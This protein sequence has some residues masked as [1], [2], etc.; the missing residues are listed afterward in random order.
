MAACACAWPWIIP[1]LV[2]A[3]VLLGASPGLADEKERAERRRSDLRLA[4]DIEHI[5]TDEF[6]HHWL[7][8]PMFETLEPRPAELASRRANRPEGLSAA[9]R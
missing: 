9:L 3:L 2:S 1:D 7:G 4:L 8:Q 5:G 6:L